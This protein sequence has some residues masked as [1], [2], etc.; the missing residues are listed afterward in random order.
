MG[1]SRTRAQTGYNHGYLIRAPGTVAPVQIFAY[2]NPSFGS[3]M[4]ENGKHSAE[5]TGGVATLPTPSPITWR[6][7]PENHRSGG[8]ISNGGWLNFTFKELGRIHWQAGQTGKVNRW[9]QKVTQHLGDV[10]VHF[11]GWSSSATRVAPWICPA[12]YGSPSTPTRLTR[13]AI[14]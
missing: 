5:L 12:R 1:N 10:A 11:G 6:N 14:N 9:L 13:K 2:F 8:R 3:H 4:R 7:T